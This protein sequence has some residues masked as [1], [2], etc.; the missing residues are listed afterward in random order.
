VNLI[1]TVEVV[2]TN[3]EERRLGRGSILLA[4]DFIVKGTHPGRSR[5]GKS[6]S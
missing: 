3:V 5:L 6:E 2:A 1:G 4:E